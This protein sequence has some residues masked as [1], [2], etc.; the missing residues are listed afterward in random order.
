MFGITARKV[1]GSPMNFKII[2]S[3]FF[4]LRVALKALQEMGKLIFPPPLLR[5]SP[6]SAFLSNSPVT[7]NFLFSSNVYVDTKIGTINEREGGMRIAKHDM[8]FNEQIE[9][10]F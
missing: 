1:D 4:S 3:T 5:G 7:L 10:I 6:L 8:N 9:K 2:S